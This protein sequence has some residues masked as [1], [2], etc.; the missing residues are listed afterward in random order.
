VNENKINWDEH[1][2]T[3]LFSYRLV[4]EVGI[5][6]TPF[7]LIYGLHLLL[8]TEYLLPSKLSQSLDPTHVRVLISWLSELEKLQEDML[9]THGFFVAKL[10]N[11]SLWFQNRYIDTKFQFGGFVLWFIGAIQIH[12]SKF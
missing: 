6:H 11:R 10:W 12:S 4:F 9:V 3:M 7:R 1:L 5:G 8:P 2:S